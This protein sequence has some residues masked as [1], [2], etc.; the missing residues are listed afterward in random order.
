M[1]CATNSRAR[2]TP[3]GTRSAAPPICRR[4]RR[5]AR[6]AAGPAARRA[7]LAEGRPAVVFDALVVGGGPAGMTAALYLAR[8]RRTVAVVDAG[9]SRLARIPLSHN[10]PGFPHGVAGAALHARLQQQLQPYPVDWCTD[11][12]AAVSREG[13][14]FSLQGAGGGRWRSRL[15]LLATG[16]SDIAPD[17][18]HMAQALRQG[19]LRYC[20]VCD[21]HEVIDRAV[22]VYGHSGAVVAEAVFLRHFSPRV[23]VFLEGGPQSLDADARR[24]L[25]QEGIGLVVAPHMEISLSGGRICVAHAQEASLCDSLYCA[26]GLRVHNACALQLGARCDDDGYVLVDAHGASTV[27]GLYAAGDVAQGLN[28]IAVATG[29]AAIAATAMHRALLQAP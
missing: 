3:T 20:P 12:V 4:R 5:P 28:Q 25:Q 26:L 17:A 7:A 18:P 21:G 8:F 16:V 27:P 1:S 23:T 6:A 15:L 11:T 19:L 9:C 14:G 29:H 22:G 10:Y 13:D 2:S 24:R